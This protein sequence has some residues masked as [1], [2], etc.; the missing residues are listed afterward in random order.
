M[1]KAVKAASLLEAEGI[2]AEIVDLRSLKPLDERL[3][4]GSVAE[5]G[6]LVIVDGGE[7]LRCRGRIGNAGG[8]EGLRSAE[9][10]PAPHLPAGCIGSGQFGTG[11]CILLQGCGHIVGCQGPGPRGWLSE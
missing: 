3:L 10:T 11:E 6:R 5:T 9:G 7:D 4:L 8:G 1:L 2:D